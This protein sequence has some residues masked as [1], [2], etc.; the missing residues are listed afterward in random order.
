MGEL[1]TKYDYE[2]GGDYRD[3][4]LGINSLQQSLWGDFY[5]W[6][7]LRVTIPLYMIAACITLT[8]ATYDIGSLFL[9]AAAL[10]EVAVT[11]PHTWFLYNYVLGIR[12][13]MHIHMAVIFI[14][15]AVGVY[16]YPAYVFVDHWLHTTHIVED[17]LDYRTRMAI[18]WKQAAAGAGVAQST[19]FVSFLSA[20]FGTVLLFKSFGLFAAIAIAVNF[21]MGIIL[22]PCSII[23]WELYVRKLE[24]S[25]GQWLK[26]H[27]LGVLSFGI[28]EK[29]YERFK[30]KVKRQPSLTVGA[31]NH[32]D[33]W[34]RKSVKNLERGVVD[35]GYGL[36]TLEELM[37]EYRL[38]GVYIGVYWVNQLHRTWIK[39]V[40]VA[41]SLAWF[42]ISF[43]GM[44]SIK[45]LEENE[46]FSGEDTYFM[47]SLSSINEFTQTGGNGIAI[48]FGVKGLKEGSRKVWQDHLGSVDYYPIEVHSLAQQQ[49]MLAY[50]DLVRQYQTT[51]SNESLVADDSKVSCV[52]ETFKA[53]VEDNFGETFPFN[54]SVDAAVQ[55]QTYLSR[56]YTFYH[57]SSEGV[58]S[59]NGWRIEIGKDDNDGE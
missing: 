9:S 12:E 49:W 2:P 29:Y 38:A 21:M 50:C 30:S 44:S 25:F 37:G 22:F 45:R 46:N 26:A 10:G 33:G 7:V 3:G 27:R 58:G 48:N 40:V 57:E 52:M 1:Y 24:R 34:H 41:A 4:T 55:Q 14:L 56:L 47:K 13:F 17:K 19:T 16:Y 15:F 32:S 42:A 28:H 43:W 35:I 31:D 18:A 36:Q 8:Y 11:L 5:Q 59:R 53:Y 23:I 54:Y 6:H 51:S 39:V 20:V